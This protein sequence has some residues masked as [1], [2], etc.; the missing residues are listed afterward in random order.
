[1]PILVS[2]GDAAGAGWL[3]LKQILSQPKKYISPVDAGHLKNLVVVGDLF[4][5]DEHEVQ[6][7]FEVYPF[8]AKIA[9]LTEILNSKKRKKPVFLA[10]QSGKKFEPGQGNAVVAMRSYQAFQQALKLFR[11]MPDSALVTLPVSK[12]LIM[13]AGIDFT[14]HT[15]Q[16]A[17]TFST[18][19]FMCMYHP[20]FSVIP[21]TNHVA[22]S[23][24]PRL[25]YEM[26][27]D[28]L[29][30]ALRQF[31]KIFTPKK[32]YAWTGLNPHAGENGRIG[33]EEDFIKKNLEDFMKAG[34]P[35]D[36]PVSA[37][38]AFTKNI[39][40]QYSLFITNYHDQGLIPF[41]ALHGMKGVNTTL[42]L[43]QLR[44]SPD[45]GTAFH[46]TA[47]NQVDVTGVLHSLKF[48]IKYRSSWAKAYQS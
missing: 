35:I 5:T 8:T 32:K 9:D 12:E 16:L 44:V 4:T 2:Q 38:A 42:N 14:G 46:N 29:K 23:R 47:I 36:G 10:V 27:T 17:K 30:K 22:L 3:A 34:I 28:A 1:M 31:D 40:S 18:S 7:L 25:L 26:N 33:N 43:P 24:V 6:R 37:D 41:K 45:H 48:A 13:K 11:A 20:S 19:V 15:E 21:L 39:R